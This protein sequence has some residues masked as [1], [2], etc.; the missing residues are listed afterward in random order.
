VA[1]SDGS[2]ELQVFPDDSILVSSVGYEEKL[3][4]GR[5]FSDTILLEPKYKTLTEITIREKKFIRSLLAGNGATAVDAN[6]DCEFYKGKK[7]DCVSWG[8]SGNEEEFA[9]KIALPSDA[10]TYQL[11]K[12]YLPVK[13]MGCY[14]PLL[15]RIYLPEKNGKYP[16]ELLLV[17]PVAIQKN[18]VQNGKAV[19]DLSS[20][21]I[22]IE[23][24]SSLFVSVG[25]LPRAT[26]EDCITTM[27]FPLATT[28]ENTYT[29]SVVSNSF[30]WQ[31][32]GLVEGKTNELHAK[33]VS[34]YAAELWEMR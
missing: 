11:R 9:E 24:S 2:F 22:Y 29:R 20:E 27:V 26:S 7:T 19:I 14:G 1:A 32:I 12:I 18:T 10:L 16:G 4:A 28:T 25:W 17:K 31:P 33:L 13:K 23:N 8:P 21:N 15:L 3:F 30:L 5:D 6:M 34:F